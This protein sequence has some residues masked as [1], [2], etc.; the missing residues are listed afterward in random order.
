MLGNHLALRAGRH[1]ACRVSPPL[2]LVKHAS[3]RPVYKLR[4]WRTHNARPDGQNPSSND[5]DLNQL[6]TALNAAIAAEDY[7]LAAHIRDLLSIILGPES[8]GEPADWR[9]LG[10]GILEW[11]ADRAETLGFRFPTGQLLS[12]TSHF[13]DYP[14]FV[15]IHNVFENEIKI[16]IN[17]YMQRFNVGQLPSF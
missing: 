17:K 2:T 9:R 8:S 16:K 15:F 11:L 13:S 14:D 10:A 1:G 7:T 12:I 3:I 5:L 6:Q 4:H